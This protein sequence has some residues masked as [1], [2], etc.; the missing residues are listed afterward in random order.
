M[1]LTQ[2][3]QFLSTSLSSI[4]P[5]DSQSADS[6][7]ADKPILDLVARLCKVLEQDN[8]NY[9]HWKSNLAI[10]RSASGE[11]DLD[12][13][14]DRADVQRFTEI[15]A[16]LE[17]KEAQSPV[18]MQMPGVLDYYGY[19]KDAEKLVHVH[20]HYQLILGHDR[21]KNYRLPIEA[22]FLASAT[23]Q[24]LFKL[25]T[26]EFE[27]I[28]LVIRMTLKYSTRDVM[29]MGQAT[30]PKSAREEFE[31]LQPRVD[32]AKIDRILQQHLSYIDKEMFA[33]CVQSLQAN[34]SLWTRLQIGHRLQKT[35][36]AYARRDYAADVALKTWRTFSR[37]IRRRL[38]GP[39]PKKR[40]VSGGAIIAIIGGDGSGKST[41]VTAVQKW[42]SNTFETQQVHF[43][44]PPRS[45]TT[46]LVRAL[47]KVGR[48]VGNPGHGDDA[49]DIMSMY[50]KKPVFPGYSP[51]VWHVCAARDRYLL[52]V[53]A[54]RFATNGGIVICDRFPI[55]GIELM[56]TPQIDRV[57]PVERR[58]WL[59]NQLIYLERHW[60]QYMAAPEVSI[61]LKVDPE[62][63]VQRKTDEEESYVRGRSTEVW[64]FNWQQTRAHVIDASQSKADVIA[65]IK[66]LIWS[67]L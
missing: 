16:R 36:Q 18:E 10:D 19:D 46:N 6:E 23:Q 45:F 12:L 44:K 27:F 24:G 7:G 49:L 39:L 63:A 55:P 1:N 32:E 56:D 5:L 30:I 15:L 34:C 66:S 50:S 11:N 67:L 14:I 33:A 65:Q 62:I 41:A 3:T 48:F 22:P 52:Y 61:V 17:F 40:F 58:N 21:T 51:L 59:I 2:K 28:I 42:I 47:L 29:L 53:K 37:A 25:P 31:D 60:Y 20:A 57:V 13:L 64:E 54:Q 8:I 43:G 9:C 35:L 38:L 26:P 4:A